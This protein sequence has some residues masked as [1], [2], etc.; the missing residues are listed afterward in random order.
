MDE[1]Q[2]QPNQPNQTSQAAYRG[3]AGQQLQAGS[4]AQMDRKSLIEAALF[5]SQSAMSVQ[6]IMGATGISSPGFIEKSLKELIGEYAG[7]STALKIEEIGGKY[8]FSLKEPYASRVSSMAV[9][10]DISRG[11]LRILAY[12]SKNNGILQ[13][14]LVKAFGSSVYDHVK[15]L[16]E[17]E[18][19]EARKQGRSK[20][21][22]TTT[23]FREYF[24]A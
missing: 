1:Q 8:M 3:S 14:E 7:N 13:S 24:N 2:D 23:K 6:D 18:F 21:I 22:T 11:S 20:K 9:G 17:K 19:I 5:M 15:E 4:A 10:P 12:I 16:T